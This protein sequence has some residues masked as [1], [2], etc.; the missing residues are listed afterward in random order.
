MA[1]RQSWLIGTEARVYW[2]SLR[3]ENPASF[4]TID[5]SV[6]TQLGIELRQPLLRYF[7]GRPDKARRRQAR[8]GVRA[9][10]GRLD[11]TREEAAARIAYAYVEL[12]VA[13]ENERI[14]VEALEAARRL[15][16]A[17]LEKRRYG[18]TDASDEAQVEASVRAEEAE[19]RLARSLAAQSVN[20]LNALLMRGDAPFTFDGPALPALPVAST[21][22]YSEA[23][24]AAMAA[25]PDL[26]AARADVERAEALVRTETLR[27]LP[28]L[29]LV[30]GYAGAGL[31]GDRGRAWRGARQFE[32]TVSKV[33]VQFETPLGR[34]QE[35]L[36]RDE[37][38]RRLNQSRV[39]LARAEERVRQ[40]IRDAL[41]RLSLAR[42]R[43]A[44]YAE[45]LGF[46]RRKWEA[47]RRDFDRGRSSTDTLIRF[48]G[49][50]HRAE[51]Q[52][53]RA[54]ADEWAGWAALA[55]ATGRLLEA[56]GAAEA[57]R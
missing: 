18:L 48:E 22:I 39:E 9:A 40:D 29:A 55:L 33:G 46:E 42:E 30:G 13:R 21:P 4:R 3:L 6:E 49:D 34:R 45:L 32:D 1:L 10:E 41:E 23:L 37:A 14:R 5:P 52:L 56:L 8:A 17:T 16:R 19:L 27:T 26:A 7:W 47:E 57:A 20:T 15:R 43:G 36:R 38:V 44:A 24:S 2:S 50:V 51:M 12:W 28:D 31:S 54:R 25:R 53:A 35:K 11:R